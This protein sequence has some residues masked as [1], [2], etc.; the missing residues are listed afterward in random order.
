MKK[1]L[2]QISIA[3]LML[4]ALNSFAQ[5]T[6]A[7]SA[8]QTI[9]QQFGLGK[10]TLTYARPNV[11]GRKIF[12]G[13]EPY[14]MV[15]RFTIAHVLKIKPVKFTGVYKL[16]AF[17]YTPVNILV[18]N[19][20]AGKT[21]GRVGIDQFHINSFRDIKIFIFITIKETNIQHLGFIFKIGNAR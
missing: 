18:K 4:T 17:T 2:V 20:A 9:S 6:P 12:G 21:P 5:L 16:L 19:M 8:T 13:M 10:I 7:P 15:W 14:N 11:K 3:F 1:T